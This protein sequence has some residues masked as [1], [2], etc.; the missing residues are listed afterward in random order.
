M[1]RF[2]GKEAGGCSTILIYRSMLT[3]RA[4]QRLGRLSALRVANV[5]RMAVKDVAND[6]PEP[7]LDPGMEGGRDETSRSPSRPRALA[8]EQRKADG[9]LLRFE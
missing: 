4:D 1:F 3:W 2:D 5:A 7:H 6:L 9:G 8:I